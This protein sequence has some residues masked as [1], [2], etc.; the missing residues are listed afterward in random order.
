[1]ICM[2]RRNFIALLFFPSAAWAHSYKFGNLAIGHAWIM[3]N[4]GLEV[5]AMVP[6]IN[7]GTEADSLIAATSDIAQSI[8]LRDSAGAV[9]EFLLEPNKPFPMREAARHLQLFGL[10]KPLIKGDR[11]NVILKFK[12]AGETTIEFHVN[13]KA[14]E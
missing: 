11:V 3:A 2:K 10:K 4:P 5:S 8:E 6:I 12:I 1:M 13:D 9:T 14:G 7:G